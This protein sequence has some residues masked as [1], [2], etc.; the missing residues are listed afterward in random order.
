MIWR[1]MQEEGRR[2]TEKDRKKASE[3]EKETGIERER[4]R[5]MGRG[6]RVNE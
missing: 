6:G 3:G 5:E 4:E 1:E 2:K